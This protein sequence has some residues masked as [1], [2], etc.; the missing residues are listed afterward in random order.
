MD[1]E[2]SVDIY[3]DL[4]E[5]NSPANVVQTN[6]E[7]TPPVLDNFDETSRL[8]A[9]D[10]Y[11]DLI[12]HEGL[13]HEAL[14]KELNEKYKAALDT[15]QDLEKELKAAK[16]LET[17]YSEKCLSLEKNISLLYVTAKAELQRKESQIEELR[18]K[19]HRRKPSCRKPH[20]AD[21][22]AEE[23][24]HVRSNG[25]NDSVNARPNKGKFRN[26]EPTK[27]PR[28]RKFRGSGDDLRDDSKKRSRKEDSNYK[29]AE[30]SSFQGVVFH[31][32]KSRDGLISARKLVEKSI[33]DLR[34]RRSSEFK[35]SSKDPSQS[36]IET[37]LPGEGMEN[38]TSEPHHQSSILKTCRE[39]REPGDVHVTEGSLPSKESD[40]SV[41]CLMKSRKEERKTSQETTEISN[42]K[43]SSREK[44]HSSSKAELKPDKKC[45]PSEPLK[46][47]DSRGKK[48]DRHS[49]RKRSDK[50]HSHSTEKSDCRREERYTNQSTK[51]KEFSEASS[52]V[53]KNSRQKDKTEIK[54]LRSKLQRKEKQV[55][56]ENSKEINKDSKRYR[57]ESHEPNQK[58]K[59]IPLSPKPD[60]SQLSSKQDEMSVEKVMSKINME[61]LPETFVDVPNVL[62]GQ[63]MI[64]ND[65][66]NAE[67]CSPAVKSEKK[68]LTPKSINKP[69]EKR[70]VARMSGV[71]EALVRVTEDKISKYHVASNNEIKAFATETDLPM[72]NESLNGEGNNPTLDGCL[73]EG[74][75]K[76]VKKVDENPNSPQSFPCGDD[77][78]DVFIEELMLMDK[79][80]EDQK[81]DDCGQVQSN[82]DSSTPRNKEE[83]EDT[84][85]CDSIGVPEPLEGS[86]SCFDVKLHV[87]EKEIKDLLG[88][89]ESLSDS[90]SSLNPNQ[91]KSFSAGKRKEVS[92]GRKTKSSGSVEKKPKKKT[93][94]T[95]ENRSKDSQ[96]AP[97]KTILKLPLGLKN[98]FS[99]SL[100]D[101]AKPIPV[102]EK[103]YTS[104]KGTKI[105]LKSQ[106]LTTKEK[107]PIPKNSMSKKEYDADREFLNQLKTK[108][109]KEHSSKLSAFKKTSGS[110]STTESKSS[111]V[112]R[113][114]D[115]NMEQNAEKQND[116]NNSSRKQTLNGVQSE[117][118]PIINVKSKSSE[119]SKTQTPCSEEKE[120]LKKEKT[121]VTHNDY[122]TSVKKSSEIGQ[123]PEKTVEPP[124][125]Q[126]GASTSMQKDIPK[127]LITSHLSSTGGEVLSTVN[128]GSTETTSGDPPSAAVTLAVS[129]SPERENVSA[130]LE[131]LTTT[132]PMELGALADPMESPATLH[133]I[134][135]SESSSGKDLQ[136][137]EELKESIFPMFQSP[138]NSLVSI[139]FIRS[140]ILKKIEDRKTE[141][142][143]NSLN[144]FTKNVSKQEN[145]ESVEKQDQ[146]IEESIKCL[147]DTKTELSITQ[148]QEQA[149][150]PVSN[151]KT[152]GDLKQNKCRDQQ[153]Q[154]EK[155]APVSSCK[156]AGD[157]KQNV[158]RD[159]LTETESITEFFDEESQLDLNAAV[160]L[161]ARD[162]IGVRRQSFEGGNES[163]ETDEEVV[164]PSVA[165]MESGCVDVPETGIEKGSSFPENEVEEGEVHSSSSEGE[166]EEEDIG[167]KRRDWARETSTR[168]Y[169]SSRQRSKSGSKEKDRREEGSS[170]RT[171]V[172]ESEKGV[173]TPP[174][175]LNERKLDSKEVRRDRDIRLNEKTPTSNRRSSRERR[176]EDRSFNSKTSV[177]PK[178]SRDGADFERHPRNRPG[179][180]EVKSDRVPDRGTERADRRARSRLESSD[181]KIDRYV[182]YRTHSSSSETA[183]RDPGRSSRDSYKPS[184]RR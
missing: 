78:S 93:I 9:F 62:P 94:P 108:Y 50:T 130:N 106:S 19:S 100:F 82:V 180:F 141:C 161:R 85:A 83:K 122:E 142:E 169:H 175:R 149:A 179:S 136:S 89:E 96:A 104:S 112:I 135:T 80:S 102:K 6:K 73:K 151:F 3:A 76:T 153:N 183:N 168:T 70:N 49:E 107:E 8:T 86:L 64:S 17:Y 126:C 24:S 54:D 123:P 84:S 66:G 105:V 28:K 176:N 29:G 92:C 75:T 178:Y 116:Q 14:V 39:P 90:I 173:R 27:S 101:H 72:R 71:E 145:S 111:D 15:I 7:K 10:L 95:R 51:S 182:P 162:G 155:A 120:S 11:D 35:H 56:D 67:L 36:V 166:D 165:D 42:V 40:F 127:A 20:P 134:S 110:G 22:L 2:N 81:Q 160:S 69:V 57:Y 129:E 156:T 55:S 43:T 140:S 119:K 53:R 60:K 44:S 150:L 18:Q 171:R 184:Y 158:C 32:E 159:L 97:F 170:K 12:T 5:E 181:T 137:S 1:V 177:T 128:T 147:L 58:C 113:T 45:S 87:S 65:C 154:K 133:E 46:E 114:P 33:K 98:V 63:K 31:S 132:E 61:L 118:T 139:D 16:K 13:Q 91:Q 34:N 148:N 26:S 174:R 59:R 25:H 125:E 21:A 124:I 109:S 79:L 103:V 146:T 172:S 4:L 138:P 157:Y 117:T 163:M 167:D 99:E 152:L 52:E 77:P 68:S 143:E 37:C 41:K 47:K 48:Y 164:T 121:Q 131:T 38:L 115:I 23:D 30:P 144:S 74:K 88:N